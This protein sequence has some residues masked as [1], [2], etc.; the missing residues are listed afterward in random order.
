M[1][2]KTYYICE[3]CGKKYDHEESALGCEARGSYEDE[4]HLLPIGLI[5]NTCRDL[6][7]FYP[8]ITFCIAENRTH[9][10]NKHSGYLVNWAC[11]NNGYG[12][13]LGD[14]KCSSPNL[15]TVK[16]HVRN[17]KSMFEDFDPF[18]PTA[19]RMVEYLK[20]VNIEPLIYIPEEEFPIKYFTY[21]QKWEWEN[22]KRING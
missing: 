8:L 5:Y 21:Y 3:I 14:E 18:H 15:Y 10:E 4:I 9:H 19:I 20:S 16:D 12:D 22:A 1:R 2:I 11:R 7:S 6:S 13:S 17:L